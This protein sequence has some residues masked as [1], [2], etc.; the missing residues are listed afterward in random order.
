M[1]IKL[2]NLIR[3]YEKRRVLD[4]P[5]HL[6]E[7]GS[8]TAIIGPNGAG[9]STLLNIIGGLDKGYA[10]KV[11]YGMEGNDFSKIARKVTVVFQKPYLISTTVEKNIFYP[12]KIRGF[13]KEEQKT[14]TENFCQDLGLGPFRKQKSWKL[15]GGET[16]K[17]ALARALA[18]GPELLLLDEP[19]ANV[20]PATT[21]EIE[22]LLLK[23]NKKENT[24]IIFITHNLA[25]AK[26]VCENVIFMHKGEI[27]ESGYIESVFNNP[28][29]DVTRRFIEGD[30]IW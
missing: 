5:E 3:E 18:F 14:R 26:R 29:E 2:D 11:F 6:I 28:R 19:T 10:G 12:M 7:K 9:K 30:L 27:I 15:S 13:S 21:G 22:K 17:V 25:Q 8:R 20:D 24:T 1:E 4:I 16:Q 23:I